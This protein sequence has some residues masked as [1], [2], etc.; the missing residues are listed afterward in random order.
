MPMGVAL[1][2]NPRTD[3]AFSFS[4]TH[5]Q[6]LKNPENAEQ[7]GIS[8]ATREVIANTN[9]EDE[10][11]MAAIMDGMVRIRDYLN[12]ISVQFKA[13]RGLRDLL[14]KIHQVLKSRFNEYSYVSVHNLA[15][16]EATELSISDWGARLRDD[17]PILFR[18]HDESYRGDVPNDPAIVRIIE[19]KLRLIS[20]RGAN[21]AT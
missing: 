5:D 4:T 17:A 2:Y 12:K 8:S 13:R 1:W 6:W 14:F 3:Q 21:N 20:S 7:L 19:E 10:I 15:T 9:D 18:E 11:R 16:G